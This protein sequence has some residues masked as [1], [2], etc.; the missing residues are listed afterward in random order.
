MSES[1]S[2]WETVWVGLTRNVAFT[3]PGAEDARLRG[4]TYAI[5]F[6]EVWQASLRLLGGGLARWEVVEADD[7]EGIIRGTVRG[8]LERFTSSFTVRIVLDAN[9]QTRVDTLSAS[10]AGRADLGVNARRIRRFFRALDRALGVS[11]GHG[12]AAILS[13]PGRGADRESP[14][15]AGVG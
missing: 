6:E 14:Q 2:L 8:P 7:Q 9:A 11:R 10:R 15:E 1:R 3:T 4:R 12:L 13:G 5:P